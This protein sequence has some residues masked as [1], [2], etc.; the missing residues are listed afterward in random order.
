MIFSSALYLFFFLAVFLVHWTILPAFFRADRLRDARHAALIAASYVFFSSYEWRYSFLLFF[1]T[2]TAYGSAFVLAPGRAS[3]RVRNWSLVS[4]LCLLIGLLIYFKYYNF[5]LGNLL[6]VLGFVGIRPDW[7]M[8]TI[9]LPLGI[10]FFTFQALSYIIDVWRGRTQ[11]EP[12]F[13]RFALFKSFFPQL[14]AGPIVTARDFLPQLASDRLLDAERLRS[15]ARWFMLGFF[16]KA[17]IADNVSPAVDAIFANPSAYGTEG[18][19]LGALG[20]VVQL[21]ADFSGYSDMAWGSAIWLGFHLPENFRMPYVS[22]SITEHWRRWHMSLGRWIRDYLYIS[23]GGNRVSLLRHKVNLFLSM[24]ISGLWHGANWTFVIWGAGHGLFLAMEST[25]KQW[26]A[27][28]QEKNPPESGDAQATL[29]SYLLLGGK[30]VLLWAYTFFVLTLLH[31]FFR[32]ESVSN[33]ITHLKI[34]FAGI[35]GDAPP[36]IYKP[37]L[38]CLLVTLLGQWFGYWYFEKGRFHPRI[39]LYAEAALMPVAIIALIQLMAPEGGSF[40]YFVF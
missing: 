15:G 22:R 1:F 32:A 29:P 18:A 26:F 11:I 21:Y 40:I 3:D 36:S 31:V 9:A 30:S 25:L 24:L 27:K 4:V 20:F 38:I 12:S 13:L 6:Q 35:P 5:F 39:S 8:H 34:M 37:V 10:S 16:K 2:I 7:F 19:W 23:L 33:A 14:V 28:P 17:V